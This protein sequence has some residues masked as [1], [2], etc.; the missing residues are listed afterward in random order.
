VFFVN[1]PLAGA[2]LVLAFPLIEVDQARDSSRAFDLPGA[3]S[4]TAAITSL[5]SG[6]VQGPE[7]G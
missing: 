7:R 3:V 6:L 2:A 4:A 5:V 1:V